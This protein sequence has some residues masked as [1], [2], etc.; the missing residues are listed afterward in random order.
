MII[1][2]VCVVV[3][4]K[5]AESLEELTQLEVT[6]GQMENRMALTSR[7]PG[8]GG[9]RASPLAA[10]LGL[11]TDTYTSVTC[12]IDRKHAAA[13]LSIMWT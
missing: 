13:N 7:A 12:L 2:I 10:S 4:S 9:S 8:R 5:A 3:N 11:E 1:P 6:V